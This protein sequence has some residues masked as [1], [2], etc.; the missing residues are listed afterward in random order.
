MALFENL[1]RQFCE[2]QFIDLRLVSGL[3]GDEVLAHCLILA[4]AVPPLGEILSDYVR[5]G[6]TEDEITIMCPDVSSSDLKKVV[7]E[8]YNSL[9]SSAPVPAEVRSSWSKVLGHDTYSQTS[10]HM[11]VLDDEERVPERDV[12]SE[13]QVAVE[14]SQDDDS[15]DEFQVE[16]VFSRYLTFAFNNVTRRIFSYVSFSFVSSRT[17]TRRIKKRSIFS[18]FVSLKDKGKRSRT[19][20]KLQI[21]SKPKKV[22]KQLTVRCF[23]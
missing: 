15:F 2:Q 10:D 3:N 16:E 9:T 20:R 11:D 17:S 14:D 19:P 4:S 1:Y 22:K 5:D 13:D 21:F 12:N 6:Q 8:I 18:D 7:T 23:Y